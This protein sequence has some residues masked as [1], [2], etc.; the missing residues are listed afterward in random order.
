MNLK[1]L[2][3]IFFML[4]MAALACNFADP[5]PLSKPA[6]NWP[7]G[8]KEFPLVYDGL[9]TADHLFDGGKSCSTSED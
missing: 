9:G 8:E 3:S 2:L 6:V 4:V 7:P 1:P 5:N